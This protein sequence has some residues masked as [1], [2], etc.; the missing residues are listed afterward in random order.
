M[1][2]PFGAE[3]A[4]SYMRSMRWIAVNHKKEDAD[5]AFIMMIQNCRPPRVMIVECDSFQHLDDIGAAERETRPK[6]PARSERRHQ[7]CQYSQL[8]AGRS[9]VWISRSRSHRA[10]SAQSSQLV[11]ALA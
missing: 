2:Q 4:G 5:I 7:D 6:A 1:K 9:V 3:L 10:G 11:I 8:T